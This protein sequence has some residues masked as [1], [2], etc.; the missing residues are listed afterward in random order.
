[1]N[2]QATNH[3]DR[4]QSIEQ[5]RLANIAIANHNSF[6]QR[7]ERIAR[8]HAYYETVLRIALAAPGLDDAERAALQRRLDGLSC[9]T[10][11]L[12]LQDVAF[13]LRA[14]KPRLGDL[15][16]AIVSGGG[17]YEHDEPGFEAYD[18]Q[19][20][21]SYTNYHICPP[22]LTLEMVDFEYLDAAN[23]QIEHA[24]N[25]CTIFAEQHF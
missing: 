20:A 19:F 15:A 17:E 22:G 2:A 3:N 5:E 10:D 7:L 8:G 16:T 13:K 24:D 11:H 9:S 25:A 23:V 12:R 4:V 1:M 14:Y 18:A 6:A 21:G